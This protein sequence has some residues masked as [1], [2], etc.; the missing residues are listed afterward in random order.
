MAHCTIDQALMGFV[1]QLGQRAGEGGQSGRAAVALYAAVLC[2]LLAAARVVEERLL[3][4]LLPHLLAGLGSRASTDYQA[5]T[6]MVVVQ[7]ASVA[8]LSNELVSG[9]RQDAER[10][11]VCCPLH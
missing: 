1:C 3:A 9:A 4:A 11:S 10:L 5:A 8:T 6:Y 2:E 7:L